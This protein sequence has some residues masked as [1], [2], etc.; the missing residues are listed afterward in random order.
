MLSHA[1]G[2]SVSP[3]RPG[4]PPRGQR[5]TSPHSID[6]R[7]GG[8]I[9]RVGQPSFVTDRQGLCWRA[10]QAGDRGVLSTVVT[11]CG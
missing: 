9:T 2:C 4:Y 11:P 8:S 7:G 10:G 5:L 3:V 6:G 1:W